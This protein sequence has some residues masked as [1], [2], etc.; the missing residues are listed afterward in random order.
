MPPRF[1]SVGLD[2]IE[3]GITEN[4]VPLAEKFQDEHG[5]SLPTEFEFED[6]L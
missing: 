5:L 4:Q 3:L 2:Y 1:D 6:T